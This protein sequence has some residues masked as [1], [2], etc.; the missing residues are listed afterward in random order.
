MT[1]NRRNNLCSLLELSGNLSISGPIPPKR[2]GMSIRVLICLAPSAWP[3]PETSPS[4]P[5]LFLLRNPSIASS[6][7]DSAQ[8]SPRYLAM[9]RISAR[10][11]LC[12]PEQFGTPAWHVTARGAW[13]SSTST[14]YRDPKCERGGMIGYDLGSESRLVQMMMIFA[15]LC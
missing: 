5:Q 12:R 7:Y 4:R 9:F 13:L 2:H 6:Y 14:E 3:P 15:C 11:A 10:L 8:L 1:T